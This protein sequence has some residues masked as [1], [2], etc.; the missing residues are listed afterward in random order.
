MVN[1]PAQGLLGVPVAVKRLK[2]ILTSPSHE[3][4]MTLYFHYTEEKSE[5]G[6]EE[7]MNEAVF[8]RTLQE[9]VAEL[10]RCFENGLIE[11]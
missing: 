7:L 6:Y 9:K 3:T 4:P 11:Y 10:C 8:I 1:Q 5:L 2:G